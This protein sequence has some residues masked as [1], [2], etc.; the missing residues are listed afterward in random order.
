MFTKLFIIFIMIIII[1][2]MAR[3]LLSLMKDSGDSKRTVRALSV[4]ITLSLA[5]FIFLFIGFK[6]GLIHPHDI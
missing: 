3:G 2:S 1:G 5:L 6:L 4:R